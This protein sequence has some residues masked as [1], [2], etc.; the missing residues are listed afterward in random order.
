MDASSGEGRH[1]PQRILVS[2]GI[3]W[4]QQGVRAMLLCGS[5]L[6]ESFMEPGVWKPQHL[7]V[8]LGEHGVVCVARFVAPGLLRRHKHRARDVTQQEIGVALN[9]N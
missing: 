2:S 9:L 8:I 4:T 7:R 1:Q 6:V 5:D 3:F